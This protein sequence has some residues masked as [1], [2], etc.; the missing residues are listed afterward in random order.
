MTDDL[1]D[2]LKDDWLH[3]P[4]GFSQRVMR[5]LGAQNVGGPITP[6]SHTN[7]PVHAPQTGAI[8]VWHRLRWLAASAGLLAG[9]LLG[10]SQLAGFVFGL[11]LTAAAL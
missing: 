8:S 1:D 3:P 2:L 7:T 10:L 5:S 6:P 9:G 11:W 4:P